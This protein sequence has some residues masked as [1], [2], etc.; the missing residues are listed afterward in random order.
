MIEEPGM[1]EKNQDCLSPIR[2]IFVA[3]VEN[4]KKMWLSMKNWRSSE[5]GAV[6]NNTSFQSPVVMGS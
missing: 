1:R 6:S 2:D 5:G 3:S 4:C